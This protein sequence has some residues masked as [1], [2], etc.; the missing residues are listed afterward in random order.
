MKV[1]VCAVLSFG[2]V[3]L[4]ATAICATV[5]NSRS[6]A[7]MV[8]AA[9]P[10]IEAFVVDRTEAVI[11]RAEVTLRDSAGRTV[12]GSTDESG[13]LSLPDVVLGDYTVSV[14]APGFKNYL[15]SVVVATNEGI[16]VSATLEVAATD[17]PIGSSNVASLPTQTS[18]LDEQ[19]IRE[20]S[21][22]DSRPIRA[23]TQT[24]PRS[25]LRRFF[26]A[27]GHKLGM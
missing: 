27:T 12:S 24:A 1:A 19:S 25:R 10:G 16:S 20:R 7:T 14:P 3:A 4:P 6:R 15:R 23:S 13:R 5:L 17:N 21:G 26:S 2:M 9:R 11:Q 22:E 18:S 8:R